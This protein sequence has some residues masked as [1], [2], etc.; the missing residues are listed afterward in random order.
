MPLF[1]LIGRDGPDSAARR[2]QHRPAHLAHME[3]LAAAGRV[4]YAGPLLDEAERPC[5]SVIVFEAESLD[6]ARR[7]AASD[8]YVV[9]GIFASWELLGTRQVF[10][11]R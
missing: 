4:P 3:P 11:A 5:G 10:P 2:Q 6:A 8:P 7:Q 1:V 9:E